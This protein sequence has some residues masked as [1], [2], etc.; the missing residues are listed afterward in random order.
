[1]SRVDGEERIRNVVSDLM[2][3]GKYGKYRDPDAVVTVKVNAQLTGYELMDG[4]GEIKVDLELLYSI[5]RDGTL[6]VLA[7]AGGDKAG[8][9]EIDL[10][11]MLSQQIGYHLA[12]NP[13]RFQRR[14]DRRTIEV[15]Y[16]NF[17]R[18][19]KRA[20]KLARKQLTAQK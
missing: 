14:K 5:E 7:L 1:M 8:T 15:T 3:I 16:N 17:E 12:G 9:L 19:V 2:F 4:F 20:L 6:L 11:K 10:E 13:L 18:S